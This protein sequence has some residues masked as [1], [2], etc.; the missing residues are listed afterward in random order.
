MKKHR[1]ALL[2]AVVLAGW[3]GY[4]LLNTSPRAKPIL[5]FKGYAPATRT[6]TIQLANFELRNATTRAIWLQYD[7]WREDP[8]SPFLERPVAV[9]PKTSNLPPT[10]VYRVTVGSFIMH[11]EKLA[12]GQMLRLEF[13]LRSGKPAAQV[14]IFYYVCNFDGYNLPDSLWRPSFDQ[15]AGLMDKCA[16]Y[17]AEFKR[18]LSAPKLNEVWCMQPVSFHPSTANNRTA[19]PP[20][21]MGREQ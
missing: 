16:F 7:S 4:N 9:P 2:G 11:V 10:N 15:S 21:P 17:W 3:L 20:N 12:P 5:I 8:K 1:L 18:R 14:G 19:H 6:N 13:P